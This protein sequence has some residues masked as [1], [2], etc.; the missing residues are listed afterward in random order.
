MTE[1]G[2]AFFAEASKNEELKAKLLQIDRSN[3]KTAIPQAIKLA[4]GYGFDLSEDDLTM[5][6]APV[7]GVMGDDE[8]NAVAGGRNDIIG[9][10][11]CLDGGPQ[12]SE[13]D[14]IE[15]CCC[16]DGGPGDT[17]KPRVSGW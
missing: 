16:V 4:K 12:T 14:I 15:V 17:D 2:K 3:M 7:E 9:D 5:D 6:Q 13:R 11:C 10:C 1:K 8:L